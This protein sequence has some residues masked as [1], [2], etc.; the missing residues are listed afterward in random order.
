MLFYITAER[1]AIAFHS[2]SYRVKFFGIMFYGIR[3]RTVKVDQRRT[4]NPAYLLAYIG[5]YISLLKE[6]KGIEML[7]VLFMANVENPAFLGF[8]FKTETVILDNRSVRYCNLLAVTG[9]GESYCIAVIGTFGIPV[10]HEA[11]VIAA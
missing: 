1:P 4:A 8:P 5:T 7:P 2:I 3:C 6:E 9:V 10:Y 11:I